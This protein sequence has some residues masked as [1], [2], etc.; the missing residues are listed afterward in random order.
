M[1]VFLIVATLA[2]VPVAAALVFLFRALSLPQR[3]QVSLEECL[4]PAPGKYRPMERLL[5]ENDL[6]FLSAQRGYTPELGRRFRAGRRR[7]FRAYL[8]TLRADFGRVALM[9]QTLI[10]H[11]AEDRGDLAAGLVRQRLLFAAGMLAIEARLL[12]HA[13]GV[14]AVNVDVRGMVESL[15]AMQVQM[16]QLLAPPQNALSGA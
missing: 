15:E 10:V 6:E 3:A 14:N 9:L 1:S 8:R 12:L 16:R 7:V 11:S 5:R 13:F 2:L 4:T